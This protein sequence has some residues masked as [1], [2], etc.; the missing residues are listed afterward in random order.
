MFT[1]R[2][3][4]ILFIGL[5]FSSLSQASAQVNFINNRIAFQG[6][7]QQS[8]G[9]AI[10][11]GTYNAQFKIHTGGTSDTVV[12]TKSP[13]PITLVSGVF[14]ASL[15]GA[16]NNSVVLSPALL[17]ISGT[18]TTESLQI[19]VSV[20]FTGGTNYTSSFS[21]IAIQAVP[22]A[23]ISNTSMT[24]KSVSAGAVTPAGLTAGDYSSAINSGSYS[25]N[26][27]G[28]AAT[29]TTASS[30]TG[31]VSV[32]ASTNISY[33]GSSGNF[34]QSGSSGTFKTGT[35]AV[36]I[37]GSET[38]ASA[39]NLT[40]AG[41]AS[42]FD[43]SASTGTFATGT[44]AVALN[45]S[46]TVAS[47]KNFTFAGGASNFD[48]SASTGTFAT[49]TGAVSVNGSAAIASGK[50][51]TFTGGAS[52]FDQ[53]ASTGNF[54]TGTGNVS[55]NGATTFA[56]GK[57]I[58]VT[59]G[60]SAFDFSG[61]SGAFKTTTGSVTIGGPVVSSITSQS[62][63]NSGYTSGGS[64]NAQTVTLS[65]ALT[66]LSTGQTVTFK[67][68]YTNTGAT[69]L[70]VNSLTATAVKYMGQ[71]LTGGEIIAGNSYTVVYD[72]AA[73]QIISP[74]R[75][76]GSASLTTV[77]L[78]ANTAA[79]NATTIT[80]TGAIAGDVC[81]CTPSAAPTA[82]Y[83][84]SCYTGAGVVSIVQACG[85]GASACAAWTTPSFKC[86]VFK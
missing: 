26:I 62:G 23:M 11:D 8:N 44:G 14:S 46:V 83:T 6:L 72:G 64:A 37:N 55:I 82:G 25:I 76:V 79:T 41:G 69:T 48:Q 28:N 9:S 43:Q 13:V 84:W 81:S 30:V 12:W 80:V 15:S 39:K 66:T 63:V 65:P 56:A 71:A 70:Q 59:S 60:A 35:G 40:F 52:N 24:A 36:S 31:G 27:T 75:L 22:T 50:N 51:L 3:H 34:D 1:N 73:Y 20:D 33:S 54:A 4:F 49:G 42:N 67:A 74:I 38:I 5:I 29:A 18:D 2:A 61:G 78:A 57:G 32:P 58:T 85:N 10:P 45:G 77:T 17:D 47:G 86:Q 19:D 7:L 16:D 53:S 21:N 68:G